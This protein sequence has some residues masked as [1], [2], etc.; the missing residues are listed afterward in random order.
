MKKIV[1]M[2]L[3]AMVPFLTMAQKRSKKDNNSS[4]K[5]EYMVIKGV[6]ID[7]SES[8]ED[9]NEKREHIEEMRREGFSKVKLFVSFDFGGANSKESTNLIRSAR[10]FKTMMEAVNSAVAGGWEF[11]SANSL[12]NNG[13]VTHYYCMRMNR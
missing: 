9:P 2:M 3:V 12:S 7:I 6:E 8:Q 1:L 11:V 4:A 13:V 10:E 5:V